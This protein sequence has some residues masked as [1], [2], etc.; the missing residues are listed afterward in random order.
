MEFH[1]SAAPEHP[2]PRRAPCVCLGLLLCVL[3]FVFKVLGL[4]FSVEGSLPHQS[5]GGGKF[6]KKRVRTRLPLLKT[7]ALGVK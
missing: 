5:V 6:I 1:A 7:T 2:P 4:G 3:W